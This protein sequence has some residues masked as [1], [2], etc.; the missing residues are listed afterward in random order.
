MLHGLSRRSTAIAA[1]ALLLTGA[2]SSCGFDYATDRVNTI[3]SGINDREGEVDVLGAVIISG[4]P[5]TGVFAASLSN[6]DYDE[7]A[8]LTGLGGEV[9]AAGDFEAVSL[10][11]AGFQNLFEDGGIPVTGI[12]ALGDFVS[13]NLSFDSGQTTTVTVPVVRPCYEYDPAKFPAMDLP[14]A[15]DAGALEDTAETEGAEE[16]T[17]AEVEEEIVD[18]AEE[19]EDDHGESEATDPY[20]CT[21]IEPVPHHGGEEE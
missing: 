1:G 6:N 14:T 16:P 11:R 15:P 7:P 18:G 13:V 20:S 3:S 17:E 8:A 19:S 2:L 9:A 4:A 12:I 21:P 5:D 10:G